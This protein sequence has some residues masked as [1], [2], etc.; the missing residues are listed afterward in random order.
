MFHHFEDPRELL[1]LLAFHRSEWIRFE[2]R[3]DPLAQLV[4][5]EDSVHHDVFAVIVVTSI[6]IDP[7]TPKELQE[8]L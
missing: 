1:E 3:H 5:I 8:E 2:E 4:L 7:S 6:A